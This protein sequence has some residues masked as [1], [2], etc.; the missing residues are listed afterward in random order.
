MG[1]YLLTNCLNSQFF[2][3]LQI[4]KGGM[5]K[6]CEARL[7][8]KAHTIRCHP[9][10]LLHLVGYCFSCM[11]GDRRQG[12]VSAE[13]ACSNHKSRQTVPSTLKVLR[14]PAI[15]GTLIPSREKCLVAHQLR[16]PP[17]TSR[18]YSWV[19]WCDISRLLVKYYRKCFRWVRQPHTSYA[20]DCFPHNGIVS[21]RLAHHSP[22]KLHLLDFWQHFVFVKNLPLV[23]QSLSSQEDWDMLRRHQ[24]CDLEGNLRSTCLYFV[25]HSIS[26]TTLCPEDGIIPAK[27]PH[28]MGTR[29]FLLVQTSG[30]LHWVLGLH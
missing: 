2:G 7:S 23:H 24:L 8:G 16:S 25:V 21:I 19:L 11:R 6:L 12:Q 29:W 3:G 22:K 9:G 10:K 28:K 13:Q 26:Y 17:L 4:T 20:M 27:M 5:Y 18:N 14:L 1:T 15:Q 30:K